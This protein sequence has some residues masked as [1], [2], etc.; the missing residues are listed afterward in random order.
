MII[1]CLVV[2]DEAPARDE[3]L[4]FIS[5]IESAETVGEASSVKTAFEKIEE[6][7]PDLVFLD[8]EMPGSNGFFLVEKL[9]VLKKIPFIVFATAYDQYAVKAFEAEAA[10]YILKPFS[11]ERINEAVCKVKKRIDLSGYNNSSQTEHIISSLP[12][13]SKIPLEKSGKMVPVSPDEIYFFESSGKDIEAALK[14]ES[15]LLPREATMDKLEKRLLSRGFFRSHRSYLVN[16]NH[17]KEYYSWFGGKYELVM[18]NLKNSKIPV[19]KN[20]VKDF[21]R[22]VNI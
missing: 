1:K 8:I 17:I 21:R 9:K 3:L 16:I 22:V 14:E 12:A 20:R 13:F 2:D 4:F 7:K 11:F 19:S 18:K 15:L 5:K 6:L 10:D